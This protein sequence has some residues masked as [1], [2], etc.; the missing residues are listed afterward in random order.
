[1]SASTKPLEPSFSNE[2]AGMT[3]EAISLEAFLVAQ[4]RLIEGLP[5]Q[6]KKS[7]ATRFR[8]QADEL[9]R[10]LANVKG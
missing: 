6:L 7:D 5:R 4:A 8:A 10:L 2:F 3:R 1:M 9:A